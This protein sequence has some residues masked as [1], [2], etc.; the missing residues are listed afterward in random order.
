MIK[1]IQK[2]YKSA[3]HGLEV[4]PK[5]Y[6][7]IKKEYSYRRYSLDENFTMKKVLDVALY[8]VIVSKQ[9]MSEIRNLDMNH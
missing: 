5:V 9:I 3:A 7:I 4:N 8:G 2:Y 1:D 6:T